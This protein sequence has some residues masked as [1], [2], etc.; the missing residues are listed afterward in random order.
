MSYQSKPEWQSWASTGSIGTQTFRSSF[1]QHP[2]N[3]RQ[4]SLPAQNNQDLLIKQALLF[5]PNV[6]VYRQ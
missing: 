6:V 3:F 5:K 4:R 1:P 2:D